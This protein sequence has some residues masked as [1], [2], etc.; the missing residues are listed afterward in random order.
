[1]ASV[2]RVGFGLAIENFTAFPDEPDF[3]RIRSYAL[4][5]EALGFDSL[6]AWDHMLLG[7]QTPFPFLDSLSTLAGLAAVTHRVELGTGILVLPLRNPVVLAKI[8]SSIDRMSGGRLVLGVAAGWY[9]REFDAVGV[10]FAARG[11]VFERNL[12]VLG[13]FWTEDQV[14]GE[15]GDMVFKRAVMLPKPARRPRPRLL[16]GGYVDRVLRRAATKG[17]G[18]LTYFYTAESFARSWAKV[19][20]FAEEAGRDPDELQNVAQLPICVDASYEAADR[21]SRAFVDR[22]FDCPPWS[23][24]TPDSAIRGTPEQCAEQLA[25][26]IDAGVQHVALVPCEYEVEQLDAIAADVMPRL[27]AAGVR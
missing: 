12:E 17:D 6:W 22:L 16:I 20:G 3:E 18:W 14:T 5:A 15:A 4:R 1:V 11:A 26:H 24:S 19:R 21:R 23:E 10:P 7:S 13:R 9:E 2:G 27:V 25:A 8:T